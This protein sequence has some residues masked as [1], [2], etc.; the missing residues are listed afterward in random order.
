MRF[1][2]QPTTQYAQRRSIL[3][4]LTVLRSELVQSKTG[5]SSFENNVFNQ[6]NLKD[7]F[8]VLSLSRIV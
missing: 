2:S 7:A 8:I 6:M 5:P 3:T 1:V 4:Y